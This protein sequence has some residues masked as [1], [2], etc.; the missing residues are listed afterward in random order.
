LL[1][2]HQ[3]LSAVAAVLVPVRLAYLWRPVLKD[4]SDE[5]VLDTAVN[6]MADY[7]CTL[8]ARDF[9][10]ASRFGIIV[11]SPAQAWRHVEN[12]HEKK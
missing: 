6:G 4:P 8:N 12:Y 5:M 1:D 9:E 3:L 10:P 11:L 2:V 7:L